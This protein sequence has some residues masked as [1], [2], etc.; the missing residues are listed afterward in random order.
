MG[1][2]RKVL[3][4][5]IIFIAVC[6]KVTAKETRLLDVQKT[7]NVVDD[8]YYGCREEA[9]KKFIESDVLKK[10]LSNSEGFQKAWKKS[11]ECSKQIPGGRKE[12]SAAL[13]VYLKGDRPFINTLNN[14]IETMGGNVNIYENHFH[15]KSLHFLLMDSMRLLKPKECKNVYVFRDGQNQPQ[16]GS[17]V[18][19]PSFT[20]AYSN[21]EELKRLED[22]NENTIL[23]LTSCF[24]VNLKD[25]VCGQEQDE[26]L[27]SP[28]EVFTVEQ[29][30]TTSDGDEYLEIVLSHSGLNSSHNCYMFSRSPPAAVSTLWLVSVLAA[31][32]LF[33]LTA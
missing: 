9:M 20:L 17:T 31:S 25:Y 15:F 3:L 8:L 32:S 23:H 13:S 10:E 6:Y 14:A 27:L 12:H 4:A 11:N 5:A 24:F 2:R 18:R 22:V 29:V 16:K 7:T 1:C 21:Y 19:F 33:S 26:I 28:A 30:K